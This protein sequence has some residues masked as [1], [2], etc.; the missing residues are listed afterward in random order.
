MTQ[1]LVVIVLALLL[2]PGRAMACV[3]CGPQDLN[4]LPFLV[5]FFGFI[6]LGFLCLLGWMLIYTNKHNVEAPAQEM[7]DNEFEFG[8]RR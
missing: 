3:I 4:I 6:G 1:K 7:L 8:V 5:G 2:L